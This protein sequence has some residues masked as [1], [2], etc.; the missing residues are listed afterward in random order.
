LTQAVEKIDEN[1]TDLAKETLDSV[2]LIVDNLSD[3]NNTV[4]ESYIK[5]NIIDAL[6][7]ADASDENTT[8]ILEN[9]TSINTSIL[10]AEDC[11]DFDLIKGENDTPDNIIYDLN[12]DAKSVCEQDG[13]TITW[14]NPDD[15]IPDIYDDKNIILEANISKDDLY[16]IKT[17]E[18]GIKAKAD[19]PVAVSDSVTTNE[20]ESIYID[21]LANDIDH[22][23]FENSTVSVVEL[24]TH[25]TTNVQNNNIQYMPNSNYNGLDTFSYKVTDEYGAES[26]AEVTVNINPINDAPVASDINVSVT[27]DSSIDIQLSAT[28]IDSSE[29]TYTITTQ[30]SHGTATISENIVTYTPNSDYAGSDTIVYQVSDGDLSVNATIDIDVQETRILVSGE[31]SVIDLGSGDINETINIEDGETKSLY[32]LFTN[33]TQDSVDINVSDNSADRIS[34]LSYSAESTSFVSTT[35]TNLEV[36]NKVPIEITEFNNKNIPPQD[37]QTTLMTKESIAAPMMEEEEESEGDQL[38]FHAYGNDVN[39]TLRKIV[40]ASTA[41]GDKTL[42]VWVADNTYGDDCTKSKCLNQDM[43]DEISVAFMQDGENNDI[44][45][46]VTNIYGEEWGE[47]NSSNLIPE[48]NEITILLLDINEDDSANGGTLGYFWS[49]E[50][51]TKDAISDSNERVMFFIDS[52]MYANR[53]DDGTDDYWK[54]RLHSTLAHEL[55]HMI[56]YYQRNV[57]RGIESW[58]WFNEMLSGATQDA[59]ASKI[60]DTAIRGIDPTIGS[61]G[62]T[63]IVDGRFPGFNRYNDKSLTNWVSDYSYSLVASFA[64]YIMRNYGGVKVLGDLQHYNSDDVYEVVT[65]AINENGGDDKTYEDILKDWGVGVILSSLDDLPDSMPRY[66]FGDFIYADL[67]GTTYDLGSIN[68]FNYDPL[69]NFYT[70]SGSLED[71]ANYYYKIGEDLSGDVKIDISIPSNVKATLIAK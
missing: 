60:G 51:Y 33:A 70:D 52:V 48:D 34:E 49:V 59:L 69:P 12:L 43:I 53:G 6:S 2:A 35:E 58:T 27:N 41:F 31:Y 26:I 44:Y 4:V 65:G 67:N 18:L 20:D 13:V 37:L 16:Q 36:F 28:D 40:T 63:G 10:N 3:S 9:A 11:L 15:V 45:D 19:K 25:G 29:L 22:D 39:A 54:I 23:G 64:T 38:L 62:D 56:H 5:E 68:F 17:I 30:P 71:N 32:L 8:E 42:K 55:Q 21:V 24:P 47:H 1:L 46:W 66:N 61:A 57:F 14:I 7:E 50:N